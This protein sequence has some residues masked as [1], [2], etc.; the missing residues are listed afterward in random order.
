[1]SADRADGR[2]SSHF[3][4]AKW[5]MAVDTES[6]TQ[7]FVRNEGVNGRCAAE[8]AVSKGCTDV[9]LGDIGDGALRHLQTAHI[10][11]W[12]VPGLVTGSEALRMFAEGELSPVPESRSPERHGGHHGHCCSS[13]SKGEARGCCHG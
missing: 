7:E 6:G 1:M 11:A 2:M 12:A 5:F 10:R 9:I 8:I 4:K 13:H 3:G